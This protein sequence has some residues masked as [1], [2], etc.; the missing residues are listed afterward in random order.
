M[1][2]RMFY[3]YTFF[4]VCCQYFCRR[5]AKSNMENQKNLKIT[6]RSKNPAVFLEI[7]GFAICFTYSCI[8][9]CADFK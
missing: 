6:K 4:D 2:A 8:A 7:A 3:Y 9:R 1:Y 5:T